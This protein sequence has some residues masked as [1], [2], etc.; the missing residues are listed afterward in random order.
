MIPILH[1]EK[2]ESEIETRLEIISQSVIC[3]LPMSARLPY[4]LEFARLSKLWVLIVDQ[5]SLRDRKSSSRAPCSKTIFR[6]S[7][8]TR[9]PWK[10]K[11]FTAPTSDA[12]FRSSPVGTTLEAVDVRLR[13]T[14][15][16][17]REQTRTEV[18]RTGWSSYQNG[19]LRLFATILLFQ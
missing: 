13:W 19:D 6:P 3:D 1:V 2:L 7:S 11:Q 8:V 14:L 15:G 10:T 12:K 18:L 9:H 17:S 5:V 4:I 16:Q